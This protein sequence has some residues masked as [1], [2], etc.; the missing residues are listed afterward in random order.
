[1][2][3]TPSQQEVAEHSMTH[4]PF[5]DWCAHCVRGKAKTTAPRR[6]M[7]ESEVLV[8]VIDYMWMTGE[9]D[10]GTNQDEFR[11]MPILTAIY[12]STEWLGA[13]V[14]PEK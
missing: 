6:K 7:Y 2:P 4:W 13:S 12:D 1:M 10:K 9:E 14:V 3:V 11:G 8:I 5:R